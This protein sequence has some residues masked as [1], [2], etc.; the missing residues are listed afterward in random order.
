MAQSQDRDPGVS[1][2]I[3]EIPERQVFNFPSSEPL[4]AYISNRLDEQH[5]STT[6]TLGFLIHP[7]IPVT[8][9]T[10][11]V[12]DIG[13]GTGIW[14]LDVAKSLPAT[15]QFTGFDI[16]SSALPPPETWPSN[17]SFKVQDFYLPFPASEI[18]TYD[19][20]AVRF[21]SSAVTRTEWA[22]SIEN[23]MTLLKP[24]GWL[25]WIDSC[26]FALYNSVPG[27]S[28]AA[29]QEI[30]D[31]LQPFRSQN[32]V[33][34]GL[35]MRE[36]TNMRRE[37]VFRELG[38]VDVHEDVFSTDRLQ[39]PELQLRDKG[40]RNVIVCFLGCLEGLVG[41][42]GSGWSKERIEKLKGE[43]MREIDNGVYHTLD[44]MTPGT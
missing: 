35:M 5:I 18:G 39:D 9:P 44:Q 26:N 3:E 17:V 40:T 34:I 36:P 23:L 32:D 42:E 21:V 30:Y 29:C 20:V 24:G 38:L 1:H 10:L 19:V 7:N 27:T 33:V 41:V 37:D 8:S 28:R 12:A 14:L 15:C 31:A 2:L 16:T 43:A 13:T 6:K 4:K 22:R 11:K 25:Q